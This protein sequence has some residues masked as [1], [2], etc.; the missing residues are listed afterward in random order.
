MTLVEVIIE[1]GK[2]SG[3]SVRHLRANEMWDNE[4][5]I[6]NSVRLTSVRWNAKND[7]VLFFILIVK[8]STDG[9]Y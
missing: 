2:N 9:E 6:I 3:E 1:I 4:E 8:A 5:W 7:F